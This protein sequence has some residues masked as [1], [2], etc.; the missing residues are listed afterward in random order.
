[1]SFKDYVTP[2]ATKASDVP[3]HLSNDAASALK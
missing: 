3:I 2:N 1:M